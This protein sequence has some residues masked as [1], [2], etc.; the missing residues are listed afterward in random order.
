MLPLN[1]KCWLHVE[2]PRV[3]LVKAKIPELEGI[4]IFMIN[5]LDMVDSRPEMDHN[6]LKD[7]NGAHLMENGR[8]NRPHFKFDIVKT[9]HPNF[10]NIFVCNCVRRGAEWMPLCFFTWCHLGQNWASWLKMPT[11]INPNSQ[12]EWKKAKMAVITRL[13]VA[14]NS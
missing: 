6:R 11:L 7:S 10:M 1:L 2:S 8:P 13:K 4:S 12:S 14:S 5:A 9:W 3:G